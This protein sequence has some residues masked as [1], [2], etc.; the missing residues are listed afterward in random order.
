M[1]GPMPAAFYLFDIDTKWVHRQ[2]LIWGPPSQQNPC[3]DLLWSTAMDYIC[4]LHICFLLRKSTAFH[5][6]CQQNIIQVIPTILSSN[7][8]PIE[9]HNNRTSY[10][11]SKS[12]FRKIKSNII[13][14][15]KSTT[16][17]RMKAIAA[18]W[19]LR[20]VANHMEALPLNARYLSM[21]SCHRCRLGIQ[22]IMDWQRTV[23]DENAVSINVET[24]IERDFPGRLSLG[25]VQLFF[26]VDSI[27][28]KTRVGSLSSICPAIKANNLFIAICLSIMCR[29]CTAQPKS[30][31]YP[32]QI[33]HWINEQYWITDP[34]A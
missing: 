7:Y 22:D 1:P 2:H 8:N 32:H 4:L 16:Y 34:K 3:L 21:D 9:S 27:S 29:Q 25:Q 30:A 23:S 31:K 15:K 28:K 5:Q 11:Q 6:N 10:Q 20:S 24:K 13:F 19:Q 14:N 33:S 18:S 12:K 17:Q 26:S